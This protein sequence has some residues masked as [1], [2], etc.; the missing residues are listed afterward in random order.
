MGASLQ[1]G[2]IY[3]YYQQRG[4]SREMQKDSPMG[5]S[6]HLWPRGLEGECEITYLPDLGQG[7]LGMFSLTTKSRSVPGA[8]LGRRRGGLV[9]G[10]HL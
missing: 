10:L 8:T 9:R 5:C 1:K 7:L 2:A 3:P 4:W 6:E